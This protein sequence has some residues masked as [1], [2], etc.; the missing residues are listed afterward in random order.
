MREHA[1]EFR[2]DDS[3]LVLLNQR[4]LQ[5]FNLKLMCPF[6]RQLFIQLPLDGTQQFFA[7]KG[8]GN[9]IVRA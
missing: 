6:P 9:V 5:L 4:G 2:F 7:G 8:L 3:L 1:H